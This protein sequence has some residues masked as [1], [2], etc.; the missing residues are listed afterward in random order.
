M[1]RD[2]DSG[3]RALWA[4]ARILA[5]AT[6]V[7]LGLALVF[8]VRAWWLSVMAVCV[9]AGY[10]VAALRIAQRMIRRHRAARNK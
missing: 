6:A 8:D 9:L 7:V 2:D 10:A 5:S 1:H 3:D 4:Y